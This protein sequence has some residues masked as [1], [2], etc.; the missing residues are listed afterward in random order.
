MMTDFA[1]IDP[2]RLAAIL[3]RPEDDIDTLLADFAQELVR[4]GEKVGGIVQRNLKDANGRKIGMQMIDL[5]TGLEIPICQSLGSGAM[6][7]KLDAS[8]LAEAAVVVAR[9]V[10]DSVSLIIINKFSKQ[11]ASG[12]GLRAEFAE[13]IAAGVSV[14]T[15]VPEKCYD[16]WKTFTGDRGTTLLCE[17]RVIEGWWRDLS[18]RMARMREHASAVTAPYPLPTSQS[19]H[20]TT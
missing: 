11:E 6:A 4:N 8:G 5:R 9:A 18:S 14:L 16:A 1:E 12:H 7:C 19:S 3:Y 17:R 10:S 13:A 2:N 15:A 20:L